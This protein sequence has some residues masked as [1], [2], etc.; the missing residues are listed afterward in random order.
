M[1]KTDAA[2][3]IPLGKGT[4]DG[5]LSD[6][7]RK[8]KKVLLTKTKDML[9]E[10]GKDDPDVKAWAVL[11]ASFKLGPALEKLEK[12]RNRDDQIKQAKKI[13]PVVKAYAANCTA[14]AVSLTGGGGRERI[15]GKAVLERIG[16]KLKEVAAS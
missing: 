11:I 15:A 16:A 13:Q 4:R 6:A 9:K 10:Y 7:W 5:E 8:A 14:A 1:P 2:E 12:A 3:L